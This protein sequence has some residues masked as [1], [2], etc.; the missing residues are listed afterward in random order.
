MTGLRTLSFSRFKI[1]IQPQF[2]LPLFLLFINFIGATA[3]AT[4]YIEPYVSKEIGDWDGSVTV[5][6]PVAGDMDLSDSIDGLIYGAK[7]A[8]SVV[9]Y[10]V[11]ADISLGTLT[12]K[13]ETTDDFDVQDL[14]AYLQ[15]RFANRWRFSATYFLSAK[16]DDGDTEFSGSGMKAGIGYVFLK[17]ASVH[18][19]YTMINY[20]KATSSS[21][22]FGTVDLDRNSFQIGLSFP[23]EI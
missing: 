8:Y 20:D 17:H 19:D 4:V 21:L 5:T 13:D 7:I 16:L 9:G 14:G 10:G 11:G 15:I 6:A 23:Y 2:I 18:L 1:F 22:T 12:D 3:N